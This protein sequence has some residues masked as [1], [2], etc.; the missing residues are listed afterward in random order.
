[1]PVMCMGVPTQRVRLAS[2]THSSNV[3]EGEGRQKRGGKGSHTAM[4]RISKSRRKEEPTRVYV[5]AYFP[6]D[7]LLSQ[8]QGLFPLFLL[9]ACAWSVNWWRAHGLIKT[10]A[11][12]L[13]HAERGGGETTPLQR[14]RRQRQRDEETRLTQTAAAPN[15][16]TSTPTVKCCP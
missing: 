12:L 13:A 1:M 3:E 10:P 5:C 15:P 7:R 8:P 14:R 11:P 4:A 6:G 16:P 2:L 9:G